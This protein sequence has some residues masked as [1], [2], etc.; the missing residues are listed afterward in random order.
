MPATAESKKHLRNATQ[1]TFPQELQLADSIV[2]RF[3]HARPFSRQSCLKALFQVFAEIRALKP[4]KIL[5]VSFLPGR[6]KGFLQRLV[7]LLSKTE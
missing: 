1:R 6:K 7:P 2:R 4:E 3:E 5:K